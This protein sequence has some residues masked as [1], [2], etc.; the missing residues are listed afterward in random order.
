ML[1]THTNTRYRVII[2]VLMRTSMRVFLVIQIKPICYS[3]RTSSGVRVDLSIQHVRLDNEFLARI[4]KPTLRLSW[5]SSNICAGQG[6]VYQ[7]LLC[8]FV[9]HPLTKLNTTQ[10]NCWRVDNIK[11]Q[12]PA[13]ASKTSQCRMSNAITLGV[14]CAP[15]QWYLYSVFRNQFVKHFDMIK[16]NWINRFMHRW[17]RKTL[18]RQPTVSELCIYDHR[19]VC[20]RS[21]PTM[22]ATILK[23]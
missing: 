8:G 4:R 12:C 11:P 6:S 2:H 22:M 20:S 13:W 21:T 17:R 14:L 7:W 15:T 1:I 23:V 3:A 10:Y 16:I 5:W 19:A 9:S 18:C